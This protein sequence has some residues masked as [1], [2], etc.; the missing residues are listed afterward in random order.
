MLIKLTAGHHDDTASETLVC[1]YVLYLTSAV[2]RR[3]IPA[4]QMHTQQCIIILLVW[5]MEYFRY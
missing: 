5:I 2:E 3:Q 1:M 4:E